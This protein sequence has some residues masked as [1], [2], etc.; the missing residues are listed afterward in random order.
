M[1][2]KSP[3]VLPHD[4]FFSSEQLECLVHHHQY[5]PTVHSCPLQSGARG[6]RPTITS[7]AQ[8]ISLPIIIIIKSTISGSF[9]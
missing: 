1:E 3:L 7:F 8:L 5:H 2:N 4:L 6:G 9:H